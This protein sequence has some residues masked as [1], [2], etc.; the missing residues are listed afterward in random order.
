MDCLRKVTGV[1]QLL[2]HAAREVLVLFVLPGKGDALCCATAVDQEREQGIRD[3]GQD[4]FAQVLGFC[5]G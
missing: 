5:F 4:A 1:V 3:A 2:L